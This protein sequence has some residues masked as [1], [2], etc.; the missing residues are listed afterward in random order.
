MKTLTSISK[1]E[2]RETLHLMRRHNSAFS[3]HV[4]N[5]AAA[6]F[7]ASVYESCFSYGKSL[8]TEIMTSWPEIIRSQTDS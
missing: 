7:S 3:Q 4:L 5:P 6:L 8:A 1:A 2:E